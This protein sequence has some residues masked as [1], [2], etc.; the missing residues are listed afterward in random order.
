MRRSHGFASGAAAHPRSADSRQPFAIARDERAAAAA[1]R[2]GGD[3]R[4]AS[5]HNPR[6]P[7]NWDAVQPQ[8]RLTRA[9]GLGLGFGGTRSVEIGGNNRYELA[10]APREDEDAF[11][12]DGFYEEPASSGRGWLNQVTVERGTTSASR[13]GV[14]VDGGARFSVTRKSAREV[15]L[16][17]HDTRAGNLNVRRILDAA[18]LGTSVIRVLP[19]VE[20]DA[21]HRVDLV[22]EL[23]DPAPVQIR[24][25]ERMLWLHVG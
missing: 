10:S 22:I 25:D 8:D 9:G 24:Q 5:R 15:V 17:L 14:R 11:G 19:H 4:L 1:E 18:D 20:E 2:G 3:T 7:V 6:G 16:T 13:V 21:Q 12:G 23:R